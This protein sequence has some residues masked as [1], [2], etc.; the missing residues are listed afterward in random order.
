MY[1]QSSIGISIGG[2]GGDLE[3]LLRTAGIRGN[4]PQGLGSEV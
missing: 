1:E 3:S 2:G 4:I